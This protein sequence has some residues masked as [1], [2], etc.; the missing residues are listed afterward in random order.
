M[1][2]FKL[3]FA[4]KQTEILKDKQTDKAK[5]VCFDLSMLENKNIK[6][7]KPAFFPIRTIFSAFS[8]IF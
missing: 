5:T 6:C 1:A 7:W 4:E 2:N 3:F 8:E